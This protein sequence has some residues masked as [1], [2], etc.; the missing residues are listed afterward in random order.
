MAKD[1]VADEDRAEDVAEAPTS[2]ALKPD[3]DYEY[4]IG[5]WRRTVPWVIAVLAVAA[6]VVFGVLW[7]RSQAADHRRA[8]VT[9]TA[10]SFLAALTNFR[11]QTIASDVRD[12]RSFAI[13][14]FAGQVDTFFG[15]TT[16]Q[17]IQKAGVQSTGHVRSLFVESIS[18]A[19]ASVFGVVDETVTNRSG[20]PRT[21]TIRVDVGLIDTSVGWKVDRVQILQSPSGS[22]FPSTP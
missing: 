10:S 17:A 16:T 3:E 5:G 20:S 18:G 15:P 7:Q 21:E 6:A 13:G 19:T 14:G 8:E 1:V 11:A 12:I 4:A 9:A 22:Q 2:E